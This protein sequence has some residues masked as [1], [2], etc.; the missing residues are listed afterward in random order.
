VKNN[1]FSLYQYT[2][3]IIFRDAMMDFQQSKENQLQERY[4]TKYEKIKDFGISAL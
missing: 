4:Y 2:L 1:K 3:T